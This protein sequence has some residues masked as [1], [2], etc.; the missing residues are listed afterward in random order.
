MKDLQNCE[1]IQRKRRIIVSGFFYLMSANTSLFFSQSF[2]T[3]LK[4]FTHSH[5]NPC[6]G[7][8]MKQISTVQS[9]SQ[10]RGGEAERGAE[11]VERN[12]GTP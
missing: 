3:F 10:I 7:I 8:R 5:P 4:S 9:W 6:E 11:N 1:S 2:K 12:V